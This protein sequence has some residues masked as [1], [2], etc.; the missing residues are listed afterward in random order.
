MARATP[1]RCRVAAGEERG[2]QRAG[3]DGDPVARAHLTCQAQGLL[4]LLAGRSSVEQVSMRSQPACSAKRSSTGDGRS[5]RRC[6]APVRPGR[7]RGA[8]S[9]SR[10]RTLARTMRAN[11]SDVAPARRLREPA[12]PLRPSALPRAEFGR[13]A[14]VAGVICRHADGSVREGG[15]QA[16]PIVEFT[17]QRDGP[18]EV[19]DRLHQVACMY[20]ARPS[21]S[22]VSAMPMAIVEVVRRWPAL[23]GGGAHP[24]AGCS[25][26]TCQLPTRFRL[27]ASAGGSSSW[28]A[29]SRASAK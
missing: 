4:E 28:R 18:V 21:R 3:D 12:P 7:V 23:R 14:A 9:P 8:Y 20:L 19:A 26:L 15:R 25:T 29:R 1:R 5:P 2:R 11:A 10:P 16:R 24:S 22:S 17:E 6:A 13:A 27:C